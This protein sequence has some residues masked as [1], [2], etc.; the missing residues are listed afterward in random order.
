MIARKRF[1]KCYK[2]QKKEMEIKENEEEASMEAK[3]ASRILTTLETKSHKI[4][5]RKKLDCMFEDEEVLFT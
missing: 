3:V 4:D 5:L 2:K 1:E